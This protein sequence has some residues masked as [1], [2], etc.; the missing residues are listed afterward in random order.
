MAVTS[1]AELIRRVEES[2]KRLEVVRKRAEALRA[3]QEVSEPSPEETLRGST[4]TAPLFRGEPPR[5]HA[6][7][8]VHG[9]LSINPVEDF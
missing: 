6:T 7:I 9:A 8:G 1:Q 3:T 2:A 4:S 5:R